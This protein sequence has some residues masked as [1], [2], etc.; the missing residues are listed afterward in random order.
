MDFAVLTRPV[1]LGIAW[2]LGGIIFAY[3]AA[4]GLRRLSVLTRNSPFWA[5]LF[6]RIRIPLAIIIVLL[7]IQG[8]LVRFG[9]LQRW[10]YSVF[11][12]SIVIIAAYGI[13]TA[14]TSF[15]KSWVTLIVQKSKTR[16]DDNFLPLF[17]GGFKLLVL[18]L[19]FAFILTSWGVHIGPLIAGLGI[20]GLAVGLALQNTMAN[21]IGGISLIM[22]EAFN[23]GDIVH[24]DTGE[25]GQVMHIGLRSTKILTEDAQML[26]LPNGTLANSK[27][28]NYALPDAHLRI[29]IDAT[30]AYGTDVDKAKKVI[31]SA[32]KGIEGVLS[33]PKPVVHMTALGDFALQFKLKFFIDDY[34]VRYDVKSI[35]TQRVYDHLRKAGIA[36]PFPTRTIY[37]KK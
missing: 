35:V 29:V 2:I 19:A 28:I 12:S 30:V 11:I 31:L 24:L 9:I 34:R 14:C 7:G 5:T 33:E 21:V 22:D 15:V 23:V 3:I 25:I 1:T 27:I 13:V 6:S 20:A 32:V 8:S 10:V 16:A 4:G 26:V 18:V 37:V 17:Q 36:I